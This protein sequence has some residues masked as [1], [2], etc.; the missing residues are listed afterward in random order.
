MRLRGEGQNLCPLRCRGRFR[1]QRDRDGG[2]RAERIRKSQRLGQR[3]AVIDHERVGD[4]RGHRIDRCRIAFFACGPEQRAQELLLPLHPA[5][6]AGWV[7]HL[8]TIDDLGVETA[9]DKGQRLR[10]V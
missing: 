8:H 5:E 2:G 9:P 6:V 10:R 4:G 1:G 7:D 3:C